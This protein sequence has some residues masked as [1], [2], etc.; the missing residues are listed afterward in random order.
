MIIP[1]H[2]VYMMYLAMYRHVSEY[3]C[4]QT[5]PVVRCKSIQSQTRRGFLVSPNTSRHQGCGLAVLISH[6]TTKTYCSSASV[7]VS[8]GA[9]DHS[10]TCSGVQNAKELVCDNIVIEPHFQPLSGR[11]LQ[12][13]TANHDDSARA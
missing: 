3:C 4:E 2:I 1:L 6:I 7:C 5:G 9:C 13:K 12:Y 11:T 10:P 8:C